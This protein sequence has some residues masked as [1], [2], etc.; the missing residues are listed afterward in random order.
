MRVDDDAPMHVDRCDCG[1][2]NPQAQRLQR[3][4][5]GRT[6]PNGLNDR[7]AIPKKRTTFPYGP[8]EMHTWQ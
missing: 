2:I 8:V 5:A 6:T 3:L 1:M 7:V 4:E